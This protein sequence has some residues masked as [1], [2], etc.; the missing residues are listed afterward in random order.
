MCVCVCV[1]E[2]VCGEKKRKKG[3]NAIAGLLSLYQVCGCVRV[4]GLQ[5][6]EGVGVWVCDSNVTVGERES[7]CVGV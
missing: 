1:C 7:K 6:R 3:S 4:M 2:C 5:E